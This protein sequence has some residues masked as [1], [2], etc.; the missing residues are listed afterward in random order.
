MEAA[1][2]TMRIT[3]LVCSLAVAISVMVAGCQPADGPGAAATG[4]QAPGEAAE[5]GQE[6]S[7]PAPAA[8]PDTRPNVLLIVVDDLG[9]TDVGSFG[10]EIPTPNLDALAMEGLRFTNFHAAPNCAPTRAMLMSGTTNAEAGVI[11][12]DE[13]VRTDIANLPER[14]REAGYQ[15]FMAGKWNLGIA[16]EDGPAA[17]GFDASFALMKAGDNHLGASVF[18]GNP[19]A[20]EGYF[21]HLE[22]GEPAQLPEGWFSSRLYTDKL[23]EYLQVHAREGQPWFGY[24]ALTAPHWPL[25]VPEDWID[26]YA[27]RYDEGYDALRES[28]YRRAGELGIFPQDLTLEGYTGQAEPWEALSPERRAMY[29]RSME[30]YA[31]MV[32]NMDMHVGRVLDFLRVSG[33]FENTVILF[34][35]DN[36]AP[37]EDLD[38][39]PRTIPRTD[40]DSS[41]ANLGR[42]GSFAAIGPGWSEAVT[43]PYRGLKGSL[44][45]GGT[46]VP[47][48][49]RHGDVAAAGGLERTY[50]A[51]M[52]ILPTLL[53]VAGQAT[54]GTSF[55]GREVQPV[56]GR[57]FWG[58]V[59]G[60]AGGVREA[61]ESVPWMTVNR[62]ALVRWP[63]KVVANS[64]PI[65]EQARWELFDLEADPGERRDLSGDFPELAAELSELWLEYGRQA[66]AR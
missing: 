17:R 40:T 3:S 25:Q 13:P 14:L 7:A 23:I 6:T 18:P 38:F 15:T 50:L 51:Y 2:P 43:A 59:T 32:E 56:R 30:I 21:T 10:G 5:A 22:N 36:G 37:P 58:L 57:S 16:P 54:P 11:R 47:A 4:N 33:Q 46:L 62:A 60:R 34:A 8:P 55:N 20:Y 61:G 66:S 49:I 63:M 1:S 64:N 27:G 24:L 9:Y 28:R 53:E 52:D 39:Q 29:A 12:L 42:E 31:A 65:E 45:N 26:R 41:L 35:S 44:Y 48:F 19:P